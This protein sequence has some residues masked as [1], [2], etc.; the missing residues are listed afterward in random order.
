M[1]VNVDP[2]PLNQKGPP[3][4]RVNKFFFGENFD[5]TQKVIFNIL[6]FLFFLCEEIFLES[7]FQLELLPAIFK[8]NFLLNR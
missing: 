7:H 2:H 3:N 8:V 6:D 4:K 5:N 1:P